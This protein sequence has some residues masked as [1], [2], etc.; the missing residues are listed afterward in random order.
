MRIYSVLD[1]SCFIIN[2]HNK[3]YPNLRIT[4]LRLQK[5]LYF[6]QA[7]FI[8]NNREGCF[9]EPLVAWPYG[10][11]NIDAYEEFK[12]YGKAPIKPQT[13]YRIFVPFD[14]DNIDKEDKVIIKDLLKWA[15]DKSDADLVELTHKQSPW[16]NAMKNGIGTTIKISEIKDFFIKTGK[17]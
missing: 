2:E 16:I 4:N 10:P 8:L 9:E 3:L 12:K 15:A 7:I 5:L 17:Q 6:A 11:V 14:E 1:I 13:H